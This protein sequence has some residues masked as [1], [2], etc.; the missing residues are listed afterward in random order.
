MQTTVFKK[1]KNKFY[2]IKEIIDNIDICNSKEYDNENKNCLF[3]LNKKH[4]YMYIF[5]G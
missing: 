1:Y 2:K 5:T 3:V 4:T